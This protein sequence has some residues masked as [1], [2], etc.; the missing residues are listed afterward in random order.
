MAKRYVLRTAD[1]GQLISDLI[2]DGL[3]QREIGLRMG[4][5]LT[6]RMIGHYARGVQPVHF[7]GEALID[8]W[9][10]QL[11]KKRCE[12]PTLEMERHRGHRATRRER[13]LSPKIQ[14]AGLLQVAIG[15]ASPSSTGSD[16]SS[17]PGSEYPGP[18]LG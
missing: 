17:A 1:W 12:L 8:L 9:C 7:R 2:D 3:S 18:A 15:G 6:G 14:N 11:E 5:E 10:E 13:D 16:A 4:V